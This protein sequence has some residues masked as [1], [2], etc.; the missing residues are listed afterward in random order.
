MFHSGSSPEAVAFYLS[1]LLLCDR[2]GSQ[3]N[4]SGSENQLLIHNTAA[5][6]GTENGGP[7]MHQIKSFYTILGMPASA[8]TNHRPQMS[9]KQMQAQACMITN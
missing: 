9:H 6:N 7:R 8:C 4:Q 2:P 3:A 1:L 5:K